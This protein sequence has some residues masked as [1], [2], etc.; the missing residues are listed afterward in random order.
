MMYLVPRHQDSEI[1][2]VGEFNDPPHDP[3]AEV[4]SY[5][6]LKVAQM[7]HKKSVHYRYRRYGYSELATEAINFL[8][9]SPEYGLNDFDA[10][11]LVLEGLQDGSWKASVLK[12]PAL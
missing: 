11:C 7:V 9:V 12:D 1:R 10:A 3:Q 4:L 6:R 5:I 8:N 2:I